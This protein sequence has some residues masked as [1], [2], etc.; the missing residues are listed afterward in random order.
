MVPFT[1]MGE[2]EGTRLEEDD[3]SSCGSVGLACCGPFIDT[4]SRQLGVALG[5][6]SSTGLELT[7]YLLQLCIL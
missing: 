7:L 1:K 4:H 6:F 5:I 3:D 2:P